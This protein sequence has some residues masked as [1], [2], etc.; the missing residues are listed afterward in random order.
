MATQPEKASWILIR[1]IF[2]GTFPRN[3]FQQPSQVLWDGTLAHK[4]FLGLSHHCN[5][6]QQLCFL[7]SSLQL[8]TS[9]YN[10]VFSIVMIE[11]CISWTTA[12]NGPLFISRWYISVHAEMVKW[13]WQGKPERLRVK[14]SQCHFIHHKSHTNWTGPELWPH[15]RES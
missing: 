4:C 6:Y 5:S 2:Y 8:I 1:R 9:P 14:L 11:W 10:R 15:V 7:W 13:Y 12:T 3:T